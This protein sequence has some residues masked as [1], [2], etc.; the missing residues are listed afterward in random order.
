M[1]A[2]KVIALANQKGGVG[3]TTS[4]VNLGAGLVREGKKVLLIDND[5]QGSLTV[6]M[7]IK[8]PDALDVTLASVMGMIINDEIVNVHQA[9][10]PHKEGIDFLPANI[11]L[12]GLEANLFTVMSREFVLKG[13]IDTIRKDYDYILIDCM[14]SLGVMTVNALVASDSVVIP[15]QPSFLS[16][17]GLTM[18]LNTVSR[19]QR[20]INPG[21][22][23]D[24]ILLTMVDRRTNDAKNM[25]AS[26]RE[27][28]GHRLRVF[29]TEIPRSVRASEAAM[30]GGS[31]F[32]Y[33][34]TC[35]VADAYQ[36]FTKEVMNLD[37]RTRSPSRTD[38]VR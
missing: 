36:Q 21:L 4:A 14:P 31:I 33:D 18:L 24:G 15:S 16:A 20:S 29:D 12:S 37:T 28:I 1:G 34:R 26:L 32:T 8:N 13:L 25:I 3:K 2:C 22:N 6:S 10:L 27:S 9:I 30:T 38:W 5:S 17:K 35:R 11:D 19:V 7:G 23:I